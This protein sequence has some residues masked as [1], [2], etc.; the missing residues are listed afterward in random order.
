M[1]HKA[2]QFECFVHISFLLPRSVLYMQVAFSKDIFKR[3]IRI[4]TSRFS[5]AGGQP[6]DV[7]P[8]PICL[9]PVLRHFPLE[10]TWKWNGR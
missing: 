1:L 5:K 9:Y 4:P 6:V 8:V 7:A 10:Q 2:R 3:D